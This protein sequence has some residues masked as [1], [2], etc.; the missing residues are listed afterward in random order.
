MA[1]SSDK[2]GREQT[3]AHPP[4]V[5]LSPDLIIQDLVNHFG[6]LEPAV[7]LVGYLGP[8]TKGDDY[9]RFYLDLDLRSYCDIPRDEIAH[10]EHVQRTNDANASKIVVRASLKLDL[11]RVVEMGHEIEASFL[12]GSITSNHP[13][14]IRPTSSDDESSRTTCQPGI[15]T[16]LHDECKRT[17]SSGN[18]GMGGG[19]MSSLHEPP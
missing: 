11:V 17:A 5:D 7:A 3:E 15:P 4:Q 6:Q 19:I 8:S 16:S 14:G 12:R 13:V 10:R 18:A 2:I 1:D 9:V